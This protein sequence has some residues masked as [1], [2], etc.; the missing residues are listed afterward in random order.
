MVAVAGLITAAPCVEF[1]RF[2][3]LSAEPLTSDQLRTTLQ[4]LDGGMRGFYARLADG[5]PEAE[6]RAGDRVRVGKTT[7]ELRR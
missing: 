4:F 7:L 5:Q 6:I 2:V 1:S 3:H